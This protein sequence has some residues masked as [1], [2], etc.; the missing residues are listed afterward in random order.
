MPYAYSQLDRTNIAWFQNDL[1]VH[2]L[3][4]MHLTQGRI[5]GVYPVGVE[6]N[7]PITAIAGQNGTG[8]STLLAM[9]C[10]AYHN[11]PTGYVPSDRTKPYYTFSDFFT[12]TYDEDKLEG[13][14]IVYTF[15]GDW[16]NLKTQEKYTRGVQ[17]RQKRKGG[18]WNDYARRLNR[19][20]IFLG[21]QRIVPPGE[22]KT[23]RAYSGLFRSIAV[24]EDTKQKILKIA[25]RVMGKQYTSLDLRTVDKRRLFVVDRQTQHYSG[26]NMGAGENA[27]FTI[28]IELF[29]AG[30]GTLLVIDE[31]ELGLHEEAQ[32]IF[33]QELKQLCVDMHCQIICSTHSSTVL[34]SLPPEARIYVETYLQR[35]ETVLTSGISSAYAMGKLAGKASDEITILTEDIIGASI[36]QEFVNANTRRRIRIIPIGSDQAVLRQLAA[37]FREADYSCIAFLDGDKRQEQSSAKEKVKKNL[38]TRY[39]DMSP[40]DFDIWLSE[41][42]RYLPGQTTPEKWLLS[43]IDEN[44]CTQLSQMWGLDIGEANQIIEGAQNTE[45]HQEFY[46]IARKAGLTE[47]QVRTDIIRAAISSLPE[48]YGGIATSIENQ[49]LV[50]ST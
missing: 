22:R 19:N 10:C 39:N 5:R 49:L 7:Y 23:E 28:L 9:A 20:V 1:S 30:R 25:G 37:H 18:K 17:I 29:S 27:V 46:H 35:K 33:L 40:E 2:S 47:E 32:R 31:L 12:T 16:H 11:K 42:L 15:L 26:F 6:F 41:H 38:E 48:A 34:D 14:K 8:K 45:T 50:L 21:I 44:S 13:V 3:V 4:A 36:I 24:D 43:V